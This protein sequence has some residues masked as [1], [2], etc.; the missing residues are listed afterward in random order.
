MRK[1]ILFCLFTLC[2]ILLISE[3]IFSETTKEKGKKILEEA[4]S[5]LYPY[6]GSFNLYIESKEKNAPL[7]TYELQCYKKGRKYQTG[8]WKS[9]AINLNDVG[10]RSGDVIYYKPNKWHKPDIMSYQA[11][12]MGTGF[13]WG[14]VF[15]SD[16]SE[17]Y[18]AEEIKEV[19]EKG[20]NYYYL[21]LKPLKQDLYARIDI[22]IEKDTF[23]TY[24]RI[25]YT[26]S[27]EEI[28]TAEYK[29][30]EFKGKR[31]VGF[32]VV[33][34]DKVTESKHKGIVSDIKVEK[35]PQ[36]LFDPNN[37]SRIRIK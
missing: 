7:K 30:F 27:G 35:L 16:I 12:F 5:T 3:N 13:S 18:F 6:E 33:M 32:T 26:P 17:D 34:E 25:Y 20:K 8:I 15:S 21:L 31:V 11:L 19:E 1:T 24:R 9:P 22:W 2:L 23:L 4:D 28:K 10:M 29:D 37:I 36:F 14:D